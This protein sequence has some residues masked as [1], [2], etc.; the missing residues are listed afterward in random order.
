MFSRNFWRSLLFVAMFIVASIAI[1]VE[2][3]ESLSPAAIKE[4][5]APVGEVIVEG[6]PAKIEVAAAPVAV[7][8][9]TYET[10]CT[11]CHSQ[12]IAGSPKFGDKAAWAPRTKQGRDTLI[13]HAI[14]GIRAM[15]PKGTCTTCTDI[16][17]VE[18][19][20]YML[21]KIK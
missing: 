6:G 4:R 17:I 11:A 8:Q 20:D 3:K 7:G 2:V 14:N 13:Q 9:Q 1:A 15:P 19:V 5:L 12:G 18:T 21:S 16:E 10:Y